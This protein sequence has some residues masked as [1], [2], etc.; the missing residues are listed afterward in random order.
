MPISVA[1]ADPPRS[2]P[3]ALEPCFKVTRERCTNERLDIEGDN[4]SHNAKEIVKTR[5]VNPFTRTA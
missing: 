3:V 2:A 1:S 4:P 5:E